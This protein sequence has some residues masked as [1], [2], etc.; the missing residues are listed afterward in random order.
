MEKEFRQYRARYTAADL[1][2]WRKDA[3]LLRLS[4]DSSKLDLLNRF[5]AVEQRMEPIEAMVEDVAAHIDHSIQ[6]QIDL[7][8]GK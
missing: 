6:L 2:T 8:R 1:E 5:C 3:E 7:M 4:S